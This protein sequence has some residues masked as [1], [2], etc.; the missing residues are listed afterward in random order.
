MNFSIQQAV[1]Q[2]YGQQRWVCVLHSDCFQLLVIKAC[3]E[4]TVCITCV[5]KGDSKW[6]MA[7]RSST[8]CASF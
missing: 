6:D 3:L 1:N 7:L 8:D 4:N 2:F 5:Q